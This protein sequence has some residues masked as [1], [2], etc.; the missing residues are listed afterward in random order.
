MIPKAA[1]TMVEQG[2]LC[3][4][5]LHV[6]KPN[7]VA[8]ED[9]V[10]I[11]QS[12]VLFP[13]L[14]VEPPEVDSLIDILMQIGVEECLHIFLVAS[15]PL[16]GLAVVLA[17]ALHKLVVLLFVWTHAVGRMQVH[18]CLYA[19]FIKVG[20]EL[21]VVRED[22]FVPV[23]ASPAAAAF[24]RVGVPVHIDDNHVEWQVEAM[25]VADEVAQFFVAVTPVTAP[26][27]AEGVTWRQRHLAC[28]LREALQGSFVV[29][30]IS[31]EVPVL[32]TFCACSLCYPIP[33]L[34][35]VEDII[36]GVIDKRPA[37]GG[38]Q[39]IL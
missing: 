11:L 24:R 6:A 32:C 25:E 14:P 19:L 4:V 1:P 39:A 33:V 37:I 15:H 23:P 34:C 31:H 2:T 10:E 18:G 9:I 35:A 21:L 22:A 28:E 38:E 17:V 12:P 3:A 27:I 20:E 29:V 8:P 16:V 26:P 13:L 36:L 7:V 5:L 30:S